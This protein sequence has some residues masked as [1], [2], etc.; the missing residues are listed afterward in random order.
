VRAAGHT[1]NV[2]GI[3]AKMFEA[4][5]VGIGIMGITGIGVV[6]EMSSRGGE[7][8]GAAASGPEAFG[9]GSAGEAG[10]AW[11]SFSWR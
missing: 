4:I 11:V 5:G 8:S 9:S 2:E 7:A 1:E 3:T 10:G 6:H